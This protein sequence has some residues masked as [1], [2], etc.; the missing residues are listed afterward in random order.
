MV[1]H[2]SFPFNSTDQQCDNNQLNSL[3][4]ITYKIH[5]GFILC[6]NILSVLYKN[7]EQMLGLDV[8]PTKY[9]R[10]FYNDLATSLHRN[11]V[12]YAHIRIAHF[13]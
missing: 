3:Y 12:Y 2:F 1:P 5:T 11:E 13:W 9:E 10:N 8:S 4:A 6:R 7:V